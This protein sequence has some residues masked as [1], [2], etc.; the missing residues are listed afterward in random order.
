[1]KTKR[2]N[3]RNKTKKEKIQ[4]GYKKKI[5]K[6]RNVVRNIKTYPTVKN[7]VNQMYFDKVLHP[8]EQGARTRDRD[9]AVSRIGTQPVIHIQSPPLR[10][11]CIRYIN[12]FPASCFPRIFSEHPGTPKLY[13]RKQII[14]LNIV[15]SK[16]KTR[17]LYFRLEYL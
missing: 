10:R 5:Q 7:S 6:S 3:D 13:N 1:M 8:Y 15:T 17:R 14:K 2:A 16:I 4:L 12:L 9:I 11:H